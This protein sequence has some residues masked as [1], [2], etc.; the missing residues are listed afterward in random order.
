MAIYPPDS[1]IHPSNNRARILCQ[2]WSWVTFYLEFKVVRGFLN[3]GCQK[4]DNYKL[5]IIIPE[6]HPKSSTNQPNCM[7]IYVLLEGDPTEN[8]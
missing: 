8:R 6:K 5:N 7:C 1:V 4:H 3:N 2:F